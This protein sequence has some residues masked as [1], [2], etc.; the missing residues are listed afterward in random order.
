[1]ESRPFSSR[2]SSPLQARGTSAL[3]LHQSPWCSTPFSATPVQF[4]AGEPQLILCLLVLCL[5]C[6]TDPILHFD[7]HRLHLCQHLPPPHSCLEFKSPVH[8]TAKRLETGPDWTGCNQ[9]AVAS[10][11]LLRMMK[12]T[13]CNQLQPHYVSNIYG[14]KTPI[15]QANF[16]P[17]WVLRGVKSIF[18]DEVWHKYICYD[19]YIITMVYT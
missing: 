14:I 15:L 1:M 2:P 10:C 9:T 12:K 13:G 5:G 8:R 7:S 16:G 11:L 3:L 6:R 17:Q 18:W 4:H 19:L